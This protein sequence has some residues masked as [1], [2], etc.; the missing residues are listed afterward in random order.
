[1]LEPTLR[2]SDVRPT[3]PRRWIILALS[4]MGAL[5]GIGGT[6]LLALFPHQLFTVFVLYTLSNLSWIT[7]A[8]RTRQQWLLL[9]NVVYLAFSIIGLI[10]GAV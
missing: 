8:I 3:Q 6:G 1:M 5:T 7:V 9:M 10:K 4:A 2:L